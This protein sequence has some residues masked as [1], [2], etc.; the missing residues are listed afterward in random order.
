MKAWQRQFRQ[1]IRSTDTVD[2]RVT[3]RLMT[4]AVRIAQSKASMIS[5]E[6][7]R[8]RKEAGGLP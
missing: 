8:R 2:L 6:L 1:T 7:K 3:L 4:E 5:R